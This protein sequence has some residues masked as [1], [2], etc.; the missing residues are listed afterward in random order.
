MIDVV[1]RILGVLLDLMWWAVF[2]HAILATLIS[3]NV[4]N[5]WNE[6]VRVIFQTLQKIVDPIER[7]IRRILPD[8]G[9]LDLSPF[10]A[11]VLIMITGTIILPYLQSV[12][13][14]GSIL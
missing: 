6:T 5:T 12:A 10:V 4:I 3:F 14:G 13:H 8:F 2:L 1:F 9:P 11:L 7:P